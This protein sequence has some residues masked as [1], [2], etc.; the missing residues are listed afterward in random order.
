MVS[1]VY[2]GARPGEPGECWKAQGQRA[3]VRV[4][5]RSAEGDTGESVSNNE[6]AS[7]IELESRP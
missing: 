2:A 4:P 1:A 7:D 5:R 3:G 6:V